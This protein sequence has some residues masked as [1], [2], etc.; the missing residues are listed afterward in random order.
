MLS[1]WFVA[2]AD[3]E[4]L[5]GLFRRVAGMRSVLVRRDVHVCSGSV[6]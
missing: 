2:V 3:V 1:K 4:R 5:S 6:A